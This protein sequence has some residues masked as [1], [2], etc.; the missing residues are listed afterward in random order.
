MW[1]NLEEKSCPVKT[2][3]PSQ[4][5]PNENMKKDTKL[6]KFARF[7]SLNNI[8]TNEKDIDIN[9]IIIEGCLES[10]RK[11]KILIDNGSQAELI[12]KQIAL[13]LEKT[14]RKSNTKLATAT[15]EMQVVGEVDLNLTIA[16]HNTSVTAQ[17][18]ENLSPKYHVILGLGWLN[19]HRTAFITQPGRTPVFKIDDTE[20]PIVKEAISCKGLTTVNI[21][22]LSENTVDF[23]KCATDLKILPRSV[24]FVK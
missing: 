22:N 6:N 14:I 19:E 8:R 23:A 21:T 12:S 11:L 18:V 13:E 24:G 4:K 2:F 16:G 15:A 1:G 9:L 5:L 20:I 3:L 10:N 7:R 17:V